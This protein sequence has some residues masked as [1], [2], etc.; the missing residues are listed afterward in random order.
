[1]IQVFCVMHSQESLP[2]EL[3]WPGD[4]LH[5]FS[6][7]LWFSFTQQ[8]DT[9]QHTPLFMVLCIGCKVPFCLHQPRNYY[10]KGTWAW[11]S[12][13]WL[14]VTCTDSFSALPHLQLL[15]HRRLAPTTGIYW[16]MTVLKHSQNWDPQ[17]FLLDSTDH[18]TTRLG[19]IWLLCF[20]HTSTWCARY[21]V[22]SRSGHSMQSV[23]LWLPFTNH[24]STMSS[25]AYL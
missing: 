17:L 22:K 2:C 6:F 12:I 7:S 8:G 25:K 21:F 13:L 19:D 18:Q 15:G 11:T 3:H 20:S 9:Q 16:A 23:D 24:A 10:N 1:M 5:Y 4:T 14:C